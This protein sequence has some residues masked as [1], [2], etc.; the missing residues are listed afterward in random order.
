M[1]TIRRLLFALLICSVLVFVL[2]TGM[3]C[4]QSLERQHRTFKRL[5]HLYVTMR[6]P[7][8]RLTATISQASLQCHPLVE[9]YAPPD[10]NFTDPP[11][12]SL[13]IFPMLPCA[14]LLV[15]GFAEIR[16]ERR[17]S[18]RRARE[19][20]NDPVVEPAP[21]SRSASRPPTRRPKV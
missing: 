5:E 11:G 21:A 17:E 8:K 4:E 19:E 1:R 3:M 14:T 12:T 7:L 15:F 18:R 10:R 13:V 6:D 9:I 20:Q 16:A 2:Q